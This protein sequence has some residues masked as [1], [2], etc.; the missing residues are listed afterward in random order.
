M[1][2]ITQTIE[3]AVQE[4]IA[5]GNAAVMIGMVILLVPYFMFAVG[6]N[7][8]AGRYRLRNRWMAWVP[9]ARKHLLAE[10]ADVRRYQVRKQKKLETQFEIITAVFLVFLGGFAKT[11][12]P[13]LMLIPSIL[14]VLLWFNQVFCYYYFYRLCDSENA[15]IYF[16]L[17]LLFAP[18]NSF[19]VYHCR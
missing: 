18:L 1:D 9:I 19:F 8:V 4:V 16:L 13:I 5:L 3:E 6:L 14:I 10:L 15:T 11:N 17:G 2:A 7:A 12:N